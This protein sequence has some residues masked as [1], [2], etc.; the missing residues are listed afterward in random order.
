MG[1]VVGVIDIDCA[2]LQGFDELDK[3]SLEQLASLLA[4]CCDW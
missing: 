4:E 3:E 1:Q 2:E